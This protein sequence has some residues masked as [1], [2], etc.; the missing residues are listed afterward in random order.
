MDQTGR[1]FNILGVV[2]IT[3]GLVIFV[4]VVA[5][6]GY[7][8]ARSKQ[9][10]IN[11]GDA[12]P[13]RRIMVGSVWIPLYP[14]ATFTAIKAHTEGSE[15]LGQI[16]QGSVHFTTTAGAGGV[17]AYYEN[18]LKQSGFLIT[19]SG[20]AGGTI[21]GIKRAG[22]TSAL[23]TIGSSPVGTVGD[24]RTLDHVDPKKHY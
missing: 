3:Y 1:K 6:G 10:A 15:E 12:D 18:G 11:Q 23:I 4:T 17:L 14:G 8:W 5:V 24:V 9:G 21:Q 2:G 13:T 19:V 7:Y 22:K 16:T 20:D